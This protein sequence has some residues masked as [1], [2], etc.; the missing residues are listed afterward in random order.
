MTTYR[1]R[2]TRPMPYQSGTGRK[3][4]IP[5]GPC[6]VENERGRSMDIIWGALGERC[7]ALPVEEVEAAQADGHLVLLD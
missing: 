3:R 5:V 6:L 2:I 7:V 4:N 1:G